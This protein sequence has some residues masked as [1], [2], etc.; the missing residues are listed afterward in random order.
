MSPA[1]R[2]VRIRCGKGFVFR[3]RILRRG[4]EERRKARSVERLRDFPLG[5]KNRMSFGNHSG[6][7]S[8]LAGFLRHPSGTWVFQSRFHPIVEQSRDP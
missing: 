8:R 3:R 7:G 6:L 4:P 1:P 2:R 5:R